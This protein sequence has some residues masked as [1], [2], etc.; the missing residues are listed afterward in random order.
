MRRYRVLLVALVALCAWF[1]ALAQDDDFPEDLDLDKVNE[2]Q[3]EFL[4]SLPDKPVHHHHNAMVIRDDSVE[5]GWVELYQCHENLDRVPRAQI[6]FRPGRTQDL[7]VVS[8]SHI[9]RVWVEEHSVQLEDVGPDA[10]LCISARTRA[11]GDNGD[12]TFSLR[13]GPF[14]RRFLDGYYPM[15]V[16][17]EVHVESQR[18]RFVRIVPSQQEGFDVSAS[19]REVRY[20]ARFSGRLNTELE[21]VQV[22]DVAQ[23]N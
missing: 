21:F 6:L 22:R 12:G 5:T 16:T 4:G 7:T 15:H 19:P 1:P 17:M 9:G 2:G 13:N 10:N 14:M 11:L 8:S 20:D 23:L 18:L 3:L